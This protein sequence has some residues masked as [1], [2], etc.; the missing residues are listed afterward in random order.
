MEKKIIKKYISKMIHRNILYI[1]CNILWYS[2][3]VL[4]ITVL[5]IIL[6]EKIVENIK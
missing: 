4:F 2:V 5:K 6:S 3:T 1:F